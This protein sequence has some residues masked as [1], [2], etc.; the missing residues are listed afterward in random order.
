MP[1]YEDPRIPQPGTYARLQ[2]RSVEYQCPI[3][4]G[5]LGDDGAGTKRPEG[6]YSGCIVQILEP[7]PSGRMAHMRSGSAPHDIPI[8]EGWVRVEV[9]MGTFSPSGPRFM[10]P[11]TWLS[12]VD[13]P[14]G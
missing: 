10:V 3:C 11:Y 2:V 1:K 9:E 14:F 6:R 8:P 13:G 12:P 5:W 4:G 7:P